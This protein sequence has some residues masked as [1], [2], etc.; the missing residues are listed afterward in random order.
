[1]PNY[2]LIP[3]SSSNKLSA[4][5]NMDKYYPTVKQFFLNV[6]LKGS[7]WQMCKSVCEFIELTLKGDKDQ[8]KDKDCFGCLSGNFCLSGN[9]GFFYD[10]T[11]QRAS[12]I[13]NGSRIDIYKFN[14]LPAVQDFN[15]QVILAIDSA[16]LRGGSFNEKR[17]RFVEIFPGKVNII[18]DK[19]NEEIGV[20]I[21]Q[22]HY[23]KEERNG[24][25][26]QAWILV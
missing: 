3:G 13:N 21:K 9:S 6:D 22:N 7:K 2:A 25:R 23:H 14:R 17:E 5:D 19:V 24:T 4:Q 11:E 12:L 20:Y 16:E 10:F 26:Y 1:M 18:V 15:R 8:E